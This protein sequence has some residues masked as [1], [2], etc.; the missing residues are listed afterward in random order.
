M[1]ESA[2]WTSPFHL[3]QHEALIWG[4]VAAT[5]A[6]AFTFDES[7]STDAVRF[8]KEHVWAQTISPIATQFGQ[9]YVPYGIA[10]LYCLDGMALNDNTRTDTGILAVQAMVHSGIVVQVLK[11]VFGRSRPFVHKEEDN[12][13]GPRVILVRYYRGGFSPYDSF[14]SGH[15]ITA[16]SLATVIAEREEPWVGVVA[17]SCAGLCG[18][19]RVTQ[20]DH[21]L[22]DVI[23]GG[24]LGVAIGNFE[25]N[26]HQE[27]YGIS[28][29]IGARSAGV[30]I[31]FN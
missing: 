10:A 31:Q 12:W 25:V 14:P 21:W 22:S 5:T 27:R 3:D 17:Y 29:I 7:I 13:D 11:H 30:S 24:A 20:N 15:T 19:S 1:D 8:E 4:G 9:F 2:I 18:A 28:P 23:V 16:F 26:T 6:I